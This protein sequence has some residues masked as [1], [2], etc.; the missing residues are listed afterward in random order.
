MKRICVYCGSRDGNKAEYID[1]AERL[2][3]SLA[4]KGIG[5]VYGGGR[6]G[7]MGKISSAVLDAGG[8][9]IGVIPGTL[10]KKEQPG[11]KLSE[12]RVVNSIHE[13]KSLM[14]E[15]SDGFIA[16]PGGLGTFEEFFEVINWSQLKLHNKPYGLLNI[17]NYF[18]KLIE[19]LDHIADEGFL[20]PLNKSKIYINDDPEELVSKLAQHHNSPNTLQPAASTV[21]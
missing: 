19:L 15:L 21:R 1:A 3:T 16:M 17:C 20:N 10:L 18:D 13:R 11:P 14:M 6:S 12:V 8:E 7:M 5:L 9:L 2:G 4:K